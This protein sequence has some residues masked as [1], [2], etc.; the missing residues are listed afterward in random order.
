LEFA[1]QAVADLVRV[2]VGLFTWPQRRKPIHDHRGQHS[3]VLTHGILPMCRRLVRKL[4]R[5]CCARRGQSLAA[6]RYQSGSH[7]KESAVIFAY[8]ALRAHP[9]IGLCHQESRRCFLPHW[10]ALSINRAAAMSPSASSLCAVVLSAANVSASS[11]FDGA[12]A[13]I[14]VCCVL[15]PTPAARAIGALRYPP[16]SVYDVSAG[17]I[18]VALPSLSDPCALPWIPLLCDQTA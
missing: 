9:V 17:W 2:I 10:R 11:V 3:K 12:A 6:L 16:A 18:R 14:P 5:R 4:R 7:H 1:F 15:G 13:F 8:R